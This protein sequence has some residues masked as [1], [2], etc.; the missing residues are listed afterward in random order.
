L[1]VANNG[2]SILLARSDGTFQAGASY[3]QI[4][5][6]VRS[7]AVDDFNGDGKLDLALNSGNIL[8]GNGDGTFQSPGWF[9]PNPGLW[10]AVA[11]GDFNGN[12][13]LDLVLTDGNTVDVVLSNGDGTFRPTVRYPAGVALDSVA[14]ADVN[15]DGIPD[16]ITASAFNSVSVLL[17][18]GDGT[19]Q[20]AAE[21]PT[22]TGLY[23]QTV[24]VGDFNGDGHPDLAVLGGS[25]V[26]VLLGNGNGT[27]QAPV[28]YATGDSPRGLAV[29][30]LNGDGISDV[31]VGNWEYPDPNAK[32]VSV[33]LGQGDG[34][35]LPPMSYPAGIQ[36]SA[37]A[38][39]DFNGA[40]RPDVAV[41]NY[42]PGSH[43]GTVTAL[44]NAGDWPRPPHHRP[45]P[46]PVPVQV[47]SVGPST[48]AP[49]S[50][51]PAWFTPPVGQA[52]AP[53]SA[54]Q[55]AGTEVIATPKS[56]LPVLRLQ[57][58]MLGSLLDPLGDPL[59]PSA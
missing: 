39:G 6:N 20:Q 9:I 7:V 24:A 26:S 48:T 5:A 52:P 58:T 2:L 36:V 59:T 27:F 13:H 16:L 53:T 40:G 8:L 35:F 28:A 34:T 22:A 41:T 51:A 17:G 46:N 1:A 31:V 54:S 33:L 14:V 15:G 47:L 19:F 3:Y 56:V 29:G 21:Y 50:P 42:V 43:P 45:L 44:T 12:G 49:V 30:D 32:T 38:L 10:G 57:D 55:P 18:N 23:S 11:V 25:G 37:I 4:A